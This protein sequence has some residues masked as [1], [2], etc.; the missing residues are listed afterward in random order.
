MN[1][2]EIIEPGMLSKIHGA[3][4]KILEETEVLFHHDEVLEIFKTHGAKVQAHPGSGLCYCAFEKKRN[5][6]SLTP[7]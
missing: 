1:K 7:C 6:A 3:G 5:N 2:I 4:L